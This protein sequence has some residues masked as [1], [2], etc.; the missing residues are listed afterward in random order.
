MDVTLLTT[1][2]VVAQNVGT[3][4]NERTFISSI[5]CL[6]GLSNVT[7][8][9]NAGPLMVGVAHGDYSAAN[10]EEFIE[11][12]GSWNEGAKLSQE[13]ARRKIRIVGIF[14]SPGAQ[15]D[16]EKVTLNDGKQLTTKLGWILLQ[17]QTIK[18]WAYNTG[19][20]TLASTQPDLTV[21]GHANLWPSG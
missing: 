5:K 9:A 14:D 16:A 6:W 11:N 18:I 8:A 19:T 20:A 3:T 7:P 10:I 1:K 4:V 15:L 12:T 13:I 17:G 2:N 21:S